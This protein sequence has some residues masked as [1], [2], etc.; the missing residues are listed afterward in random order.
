MI[1]PIFSREIDE[2]F[3]AHRLKSTSLA[4]VA[5][6]LVCTGLWAYAFYV[7]GVFRWDLFAV[8]GTGVVV[9]LGAMV[10]FRL[11]D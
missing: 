8:F 2:R 11:T 3:L 4:G 7:D 9:K 10:F 5:A 1:F 6:L